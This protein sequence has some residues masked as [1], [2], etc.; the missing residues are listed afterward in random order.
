MQTNETKKYF[1]ELGFFLFVVF[2]S[3]LI[4]CV[5]ISFYDLDIKIS[6]SHID[7]SV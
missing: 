1:T 5:S 7:L 6:L 4:L 2:I 3:E